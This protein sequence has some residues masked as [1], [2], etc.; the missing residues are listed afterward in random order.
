MPRVYWGWIMLFS[1]ALMTFASSGSRFS[2]GVFLIPMSEDLHWG[3]DQ[4]ALAASLNLILAGLLRAVVGFMVDR[5]GAKFVLISGVFLCGSALLL[6][7]VAQELW[8]FYLSY[9]V[10][11]AIGFAFASPV[12]VTPVVSAWFMKRRSLAM[13]IGATGTAL[14]QLV[15]VPLAMA[16]VL[17]VGWENAYRVIA[18]FMLAIVMPVGYLL[19]FNRP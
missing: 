3:R 2:F 18:L 7:S 6:T 1:I 13:S 17:T 19:F 16:A 10:L 14:G 12:V 8:Q 11:L 4:L 5:F 15:T 9:G